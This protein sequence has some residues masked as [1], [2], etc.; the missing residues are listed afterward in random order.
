MLEKHTTYPEKELGMLW[1]QVRGIPKKSL[2]ILGYAKRIPQLTWTI[3][4]TLQ[5]PLINSLIAEEGTS[6]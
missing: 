5:K 1:W 6:F 3:N 2:G 4:L